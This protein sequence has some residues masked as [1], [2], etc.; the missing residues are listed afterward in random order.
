M[1]LINEVLYGSL[2]KAYI[3]FLIPALLA[4]I[5]NSIYCLADVYFISISTSAN[6]LAALNICMP[7]FSLYSAIGLTFGVGGAAIMSIAQGQNN[8]ELRNKAF[9][10]SVLGMAFFGLL[11][12][13]IGLV[14]P[15]QCAYLLGSNDALLHEV[16]L[17]FMPINTCAFFFVF[18][19]AGSILLRNDQAI[20][21]AMISSIGPNLLNIGLDYLF[22][23]VFKW[24]IA[25]AA[26]ATGFSA[27][28]GFI[29]MSFHFVLKR[30]T[31]HFV[32]DYR[33]LF[34]WKRIISAGISSGVL[35]ISIASIAL[36]LNYVIMAFS[37]AIYLS[38]YAIVSNIA[39]V[40]KGLLSG[41]AQALQPMISL[42]HGAK[43]IDRSKKVL[44]LGCIYA[45]SFALIIFTISM[46]FPKQLA[47]IFANNDQT[48]IA[49]AAKGII[50]YFPCFLFMS[51]LMIM[52]IYMQA[53]EQ[54]NKATAITFLKGFVFMGISLFT[55][56]FFIG[57]DAIFICSVVSE[58]LACFIALIYVKKSK[59]I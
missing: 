25:G 28:V 46:F 59:F 36:V 21:L 17:Y 42:N 44:K 7:L 54:G 4:C 40:V 18:H 43:Q 12:G 51:V 39:Y 3:R 16:L 22:C 2:N 5:S 10:Y 31:V 55:L 1:N 15:K 30:N 8:D 37:S 33:D 50:L 49:I 19:Y 26:I 20:K 14:F 23:A 58:A 6:A 24:G 11:L 57:I 52:L 53:S 9:S 29:I 34:L 13:L 47:A 32:K 35:E 45:F 41:F 38:A 48:L 27:M 56:L